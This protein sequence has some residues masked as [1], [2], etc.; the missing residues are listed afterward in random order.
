MSRPN[1]SA[2]WS[3]FLAAE[4]GGRDAEAE[5]ALAEL[6]RALPERR[7]R[8]GFADRVMLRVAVRP[9]WFARPAVRFALAATLVALAVSAAL[10]VPLLAPLA[11]LIG[12]GGALGFAVEGLSRIATRF[13]E[14]LAAWAPL[15]TVGRAL[16]RALL[17]PRLAGLLVVQF[18]IAALALRGLAGVVSA[19]RSTVHVAH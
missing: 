13:A 1:A 2:P 4:A 3:R 15:A 14:G 19:Q 11:G 6:F 10:L 16:G 5:A 17:E 12:P 18:L 7:P 9:G 8:P